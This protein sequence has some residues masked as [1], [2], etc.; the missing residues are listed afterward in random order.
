MRMHE[1]RRTFSFELGELGNEVSDVIAARVGFLRL[2]ERIE[3]SE[4][5]LRIRSGRG[6]PLPSTIATIVTRSVP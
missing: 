6:G 3:D 5:G 2:G 1:A 4:I